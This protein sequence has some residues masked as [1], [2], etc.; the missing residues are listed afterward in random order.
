MSSAFTAADRTRG[1]GLVAFDGPAFVYVVRVE[2]IAA[3]EVLAGATVFTAALTGGALIG[4]AL[5]EAVLD[6]AALDGTV[7]DGA[8]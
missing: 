1:A 6:D 5:V 7:L 2:A 4:R 8:V 3:L